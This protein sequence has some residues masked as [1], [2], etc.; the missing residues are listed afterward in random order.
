MGGKPTVTSGLFLSSLV[1]LGAVACTSMFMKGSEPAKKPPAQ[2]M[3]VFHAPTCTTSDGQTIE[4]TKGSYALAA[5]RGTLVLYELDDRGEGAKITNHWQDDEGHHFVTYV[6]RKQGWH[7]VIPDEPGR[8]G[9]RHVYLGGTYTV[10]QAQGH[11]QLQ[12]TPVA[13]CPLVLE[14]Q[15]AEAPPPPPS[16]TTPPPPEPTAV[17]TAAPPPPVDPSGRV[18]APGATQMCYGPAACQG[19]QQC[20]PDGSAWGACDCGSK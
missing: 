19:A 14:G 18:C 16:A 9:M 8:Q 7:Y 11:F 13:S 1:A 20:V 2:S 4:G 12:G 6:P 17:P 3:A 15:T 10:D 5:E